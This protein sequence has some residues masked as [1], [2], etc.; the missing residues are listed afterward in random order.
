MSRGL[1]WEKAKAKS[2]SASVHNG[3]LTRERQTYYNKHE[4]QLD[5]ILL[6]FEWEDDGLVLGVVEFGGE[7][8]YARLDRTLDRWTFRMSDWQVERIAP[9]WD[10]LKDTILSQHG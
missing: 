1:N 9:L 10:G 3:G 6:T 2:G 8:Y 5:R 4:R 7:L